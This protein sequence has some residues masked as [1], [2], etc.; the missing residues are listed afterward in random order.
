MGSI[1]TIQVQG[2]T[3]I[4]KY[5]KSTSCF[6]LLFAYLNFEWEREREKEQK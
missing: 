4:E 6:L 5:T 3:H 1:V 2:Q